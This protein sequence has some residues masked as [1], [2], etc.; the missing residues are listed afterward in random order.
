MG[1][2]V[3]EKEN[4]KVSKSVR[5]SVGDDADVSERMHVRYVFNTKL[6]QS[7]VEFRTS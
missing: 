3:V 4:V 7:F 5:G 2:K 1:W 6:L